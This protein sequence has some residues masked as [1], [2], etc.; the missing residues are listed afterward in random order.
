MYKITKMKNQNIST[1]LKP[2]FTNFWKETL[3][4]LPPSEISTLELHF[5]QII[6]KFSSL[7]TQSQVDRE[8]QIIISAIENG[9]FFADPE[10]FKNT[11][12]QRFR[13]HFSLNKTDLVS[14]GIYYPINDF[15]ELLPVNRKADFAPFFSTSLKNKEEL[16]PELSSGKAKSIISQSSLLP[17][18]AKMCSFP[19]VFH[20]HVSSL[21]L[22]HFLVFLLRDL[23]AID[24]FDE[25]IRK[26]LLVRQQGSF[27]KIDL[28]EAVG[29][30]GFLA[31]NSEFGEKF[32]VLLQVPSMQNSEGKPNQTCLLRFSGN[33]SP[34]WFFFWS[35][36]NSCKIC[37]LLRILFWI[38][39]S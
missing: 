38:P 22:S 39:Q 5:D 15:S 23:N 37:F 27:N 9:T 21:A 36:G 13:T 33:M 11:F 29:L 31:S 4:N 3:P 30:K 12:I 16:L 19:S 1:I 28:L 20:H 6:D 24:N 25:E 18:D 26:H 2:K 7:T 8:T 34:S 17:K 35:W 10:I 14:Y 32:E